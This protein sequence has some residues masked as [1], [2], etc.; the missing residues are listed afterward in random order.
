[1]KI[2]RNILFNPGPATTTDSV[3]KALLVPDICPREKDFT[4]LTDSIRQDLIKVVHGGKDYVCVLLTGSGTA[5]MDACINS[6][7]PAEGKI[8]I[9]NNGAYGKR[10]VDIAKAY[11]LKT[12]EIKSSSHQKLDVTYVERAIQSDSKICCL[13]MV[14][15]ETTTG[16]L[17]PL[18]AIGKLA[19]KYGC[20][21]LVDAISSYAGIPIDL[22]KAQVD[23]LMSTSNKC[24]QGMPGVAF[25]ICRRKKL[26]AL[27]DN[28]KRSYYLNL[29]EEYLYYKKTGETRFTPPVQVLYALRQAINE[30][31]KEGA[32][33]RYNRYTEN[34]KALREGIERL[35]F[36]SLLNK[37]DESHILMTIVEP[38]HPKYDFNRMHDL[39]YQK[40]FTIYPGKIEQ[41]T[42]RLANMGDIHLRDIKNF[43]RALEQTLNVMGVQLRK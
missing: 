35:G 24:I 10:M 25:V 1:M 12:V 5:A 37:E 20:V 38:V 41:R 27:K 34:W 6:V 42:F 36:Q 4:Q 33:G 30:Y 19:K 32:D 43:L 16:L 9:I 22:R 17:N 40:G 11:G 31:L 15:H 29:Y 2:R 28:P 7:V 14:H 21:F 3:K 13:A 8:A 23:F 26:E 18:E 39:L